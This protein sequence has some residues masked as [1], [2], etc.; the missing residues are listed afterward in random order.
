M[1]KEGK[2]SDVLVFFFHFP[3]ILDK[4]IFFIIFWPCVIENFSFVQ[5]GSSFWFWC[6]ILHREWNGN[7]KSS[8]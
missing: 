8:S 4:F 2:A 7:T 5:H 6:I 3:V 1:S